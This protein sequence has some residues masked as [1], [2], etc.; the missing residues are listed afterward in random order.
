MGRLLHAAVLL[1][2]I[3]AAGAVRADGITGSI[4]EDVTS[5]HGDN[6]DPGG[7]R[8][9]F[10]TVQL[11]QR[12]RLG[13]ERSLFPMLRLNAGGSFEQINAETTTLGVSNDY[14]N[15]TTS[16]F[17][18]LTLA[19][20][21]LGAT[22]GYSRRQFLATGSPWFVNEEPALTVGWRPL[23]LP[24]FSLRLSRPSTYDA[25]R[26]I[27][28]LTTTQ[29]LFSAQYL[30]SRELDLRYALEYGR[31]QD[32]LHG[33]DTTSVT[34]YGSANYAATLEPWRTS[35]AAGLNATVRRTMVNASGQGGEILTPVLP[36][37]GLSA[38]ETFPATPELVTLVPNAA[39]IDGVTTLSTGLNIGFGPRLAGD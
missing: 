36:V 17:G 23:G 8:Q 32:H 3:L 38:V 25:T 20:D 26:T 39:L 12:Y 24:S 18:N 22:A 28:D 27:E 13:L 1:G 15:R 4:E 11:I 37:T 35:V 7:G 29:A 14:L 31:P 6:T 9:R 34:Q 2:G 21:F 5:T 19:T 10:E 16:F 33:T 30:P